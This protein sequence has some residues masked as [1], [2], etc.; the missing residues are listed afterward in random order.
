MTPSSQATSPQTSATL[1]S[2]TQVAHSWLHLLQL[3]YADT[4][5]PSLRRHRSPYVFHGSHDATFPLMT[6]LQRLGGD[7]RASERHLLRNFRKYAQY[8]S[9][10]LAARGGDSIWHWLALGQHHGLPTRLL[11]FTYS[12]LVAL[13]FA[14]RD[15]RHFEHDG[16]VWMVN[17]AQVGAAMPARMRS[18][19]EQEGA[20]VFT[21]DLL[22]EVMD[23]RSGT[24]RFDLSALH[25]LETPGE[26]P[27]MAFIEPPSIDERIVQQYA[28][29]GFL[30]DPQG[31]IGPWLLH[32]PGICSR[33]I[34]PAALKWEVRD[35]LDQS[36]VNER[37]LFPGLS[38]LARWPGLYYTASPPPDGTEVPEDRGPGSIHRGR[39]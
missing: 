22:Q 16:V 15:L 26:P 8:G 21:V 18:G 25:A 31:E 32:R 5:Q 30:S 7:L 33:V 29:F 17:H 19:L 37:T 28:L 24:T 3:L 39:S 10:Q 36:N 14:T 38:G 12:P 20:Q 34:I 11:D 13:H 4:W 9:S 27:F 2:V 35:A 6:S 23:G 1:E